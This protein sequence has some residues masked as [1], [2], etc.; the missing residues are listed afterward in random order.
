MAVAK[1]DP[2]SVFRQVHFRSPSELCALSTRQASVK[3]A[4]HFPKSVAAEEAAR[5]EAE[6]EA[7]DLDTGAFVIVRWKV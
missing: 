1:D 2:D 3:T 7:L 6:G 4:I 5:Q